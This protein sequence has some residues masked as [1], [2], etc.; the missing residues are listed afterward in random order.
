MC[1]RPL[2]DTP[3]IRKMNKKGTCVHKHMYACSLNPYLDG[4]AGGPHLYPKV[5][6][7]ID[8]IYEFLNLGFKMFRV[9]GG[10]KLLLAPP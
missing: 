4:G 8:F 9:V 6:S 10:F 1:K 7:Q 3:P 5:K 2:I